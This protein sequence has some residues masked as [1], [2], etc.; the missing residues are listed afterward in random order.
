MPRGFDPEEREHI[1][2]RLFEIGERLFSSSPYTA[3]SIDSCVEEAGLSKGAFY[4]FFPSKEDFF[5]QLTQQ[6]ERREKAGISRRLSDRWELIPA[7]DLLNM[8]FTEQFDLLVRIPLFERALDPALL[9]RIIRKIG[10]KRFAESMESDRDFWLGWAGRFEERGMTA[11]PQKQETAFASVKN[12]IYLA[13]HRD[14]IGPSWRS[15]LEYLIGLVVRD[16]FG[17]TND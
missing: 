11:D 10:A 13:L 8:F 17:E 15:D 3:V 16:L 12:L 5:F 1:R 2:N 6:V 14:R 4:S 7:P 9:E